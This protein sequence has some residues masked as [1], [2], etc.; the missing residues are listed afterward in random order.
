MNYSGLAKIIPFI[1]RAQVRVGPPWSTAELG[2]LFR[3]AH[4]LRQS[5]M[6][7]E[8]DMGLSDE[9]DPWFVFY[10]T[11]T[12]DVIAHFARLNGLVVVHGLSASG[13]ISGVDLHDVVRRI[14]P[15]QAMENQQRTR[16]DNSVVL[17]PFMMLVAFVAASFLATEESQAA[18]VAGDSADS[19]RVR[20]VDTSKIKADWLDRAIA[21]LNNKFKDRSEA[22]SSEATRKLT[23]TDTNQHSMALVMLAA[24]IIQAKAD[25]AALVDDVPESGL[26]LKY[27]P[28]AGKLVAD[29]TSASNEAG[30]LLDASSPIAP[31]KAA[32]AHLQ[33]ADHAGQDPAAPGDVQTDGAAVDQGATGLSAGSGQGLSSVPLAPTSTPSPVTEIV[34][35][36][37]QE[38]LNLPETVPAGGGQLLPGSNGNL[39]GKAVIS[40]LS[41]SPTGPASFDLTFEGGTLQFHQNLTL[42]DVRLVDLTAGQSGSAQDAL[43]VDGSVS[44]DDVTLIVTSQTGTTLVLTNAQESI[45]IDTGDIRIRNFTFGVDQLVLQHPEVM[46]KTPEVLYSYTGDIIIKF[47]EDTRVT[48]LGV[49]NP[50]DLIASVA[51]VSTL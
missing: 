20:H 32:T 26:E 14:A 51:S 10:S 50:S 31:G 24:A 29:A 25:L 45:L 19:A 36:R 28:V 9:G 49:F 23:Q 39:V 3:V 38:Y 8:T 30:A 11:Q 18:A 7:I 2:E 27:A 6:A 40:T 35:E 48:L 12:E 46:A 16:S 37:G 41:V 5:G 21:L 22:A 13:T 42:L 33:S 44:L 1:P 17:H 4:V 34:S 47:S 43:S 15:V